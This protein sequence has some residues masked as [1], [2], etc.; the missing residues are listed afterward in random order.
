M[1]ER[2]WPAR[3]TGLGITSAII[4]VALSLISI[5]CVRLEL[6]ALRPALLTGLAGAL[7][8]MFGVLMLIIGLVSK[9]ATGRTAKAAIALVVAGA[10][11][12]Q[13]VGAIVQGRSVPPIH[14][15]STDTADPPQFD[16]L[17]GARAGA[18]NPPEYAGAETARQQAEAYPD[19]ETLRFDGVAVPRALE[20]AEAAARAIGLEAVVAQPGKNL[21]EGTDVTFWYG[22]KD[23]VVVRVRESGSGSIV[24]IRSKS[25]VGVSDLGAN[26]KRVRALSEELR[27]QLGG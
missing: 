17:L 16:A 11:S 3:I 21:V 2:T 12:A 24:D 15:I 5:L 20:A 7:I 10:I 19:I 26:A 8:A 9:G 13:M 27:R 22:Y 6:L 25:R 18:V 1:S 14:D 4:A 23:D